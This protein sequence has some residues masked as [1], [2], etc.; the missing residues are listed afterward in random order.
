[1]DAKEADEVNWIGGVLRLMQDA[2]APQLLGD[3]ADLVEG[4]SQPAIAQGRPGPGG[5]RTGW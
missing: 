5:G 2:V 4:G 1:M 3:Q